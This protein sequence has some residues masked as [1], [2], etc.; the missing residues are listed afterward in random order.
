MGSLAQTCLHW[1]LFLWSLL[2]LLVQVVEIGQT[3]RLYSSLRH[4]SFTKKTGMRLQS[5]LPPKQKLN[6][7]YT[8]FKC[9]LRMHFLILVMI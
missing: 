6:V 8:S 1:I 7:Y 3:R 5:M 9:Q 2:R 4:W